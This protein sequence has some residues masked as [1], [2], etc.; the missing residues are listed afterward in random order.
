MP[1]LLLK[2]E[3]LDLLRCMLRVVLL[4]QEPLPRVAMRAQDGSVDVRPGTRAPPVAGQ[5]P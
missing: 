1:T 3:L 2:Y 4:Y 5:D